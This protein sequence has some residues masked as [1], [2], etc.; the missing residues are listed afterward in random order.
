[1]YLG[2]LNFS[3]LL[4]FGVAGLVAT[5]SPDPESRPPLPSEV[6][7]A[8]FAAPP[9]LPD[10]EVADRV[11]EALRLPLSGPVPEWAIRRDGEGRLLLNFYTVNGPHRVTV[12]PEED[13]LRIETRRNGFWRYLSNLHATTLRESRDDWRIRLWT[14]NIELAIWSLIA[15]VVSG[16]YLWLASRPRYRLAVNA[17]FAGNG[18]FLLLYVLT[19]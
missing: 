11:Y 4:V 17:F 2:L 3:N 12:L 16:L 19:R 14:Y 10:K 18:A 13:R 5:V 15:M 9:G 8:D 7:F 6:R 1:M